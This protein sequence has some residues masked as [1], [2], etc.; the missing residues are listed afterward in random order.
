[1]PGTHGVVEPPTPY[2]DA[3]AKKHHW[4]GITQDISNALK[5]RKLTRAERSLEG[6]DSLLERWALIRYTDS[7]GD[8]FATRKLVIVKLK[9]VRVFAEDA[10]ERSLSMWV[11]ELMRLGEIDRP[12]VVYPTPK[13]LLLRSEVPARP[14]IEMRAEAGEKFSSQPELLEYSREEDMFR[15]L[16][17]SIDEVEVDVRFVVSPSRFGTQNRGSDS[18]FVLRVKDT[19]ANAGSKARKPAPV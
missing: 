17:G 11:E 14:Q 12:P 1:M 15:P 9:K 3:L 13:R 19:A 10:I 6:F 5:H 4:F 16:R 18:S 7:S 8:Y 2:R